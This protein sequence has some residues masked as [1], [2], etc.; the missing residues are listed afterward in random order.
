MKALTT[1]TLICLS[2][3]EI[4]GLES[5]VPK[6]EWFKNVS[7]NGTYIAFS[8]ENKLHLYDTDDG[9]L[10]LKINTPRT[11]KA[12]AFSHDEQNLVLMDD[13]YTVL[14][15]DLASNQKVWTTELRQF[16]EMGERDPKDD[17]RIMENM[18]FDMQNNRISIF[19]IKRAK[20][21]LVVLMALDAASGDFIGY[22]EEQ[23]YGKGPLYANEI[24]DLILFRPETIEAVYIDRYY[25]YTQ[26]CEFDSSGE[27]ELS[28]GESGKPSVLNRKEFHDFAYNSEGNYY[29]VYFEDK[30]LNDSYI[31]KY[32]YTEFA[33]KYK[34]G[35]IPDPWVKV[36][37]TNDKMI[38]I[39]EGKA[40]LF[41]LDANGDNKGNVKSTGSY[42]INIGELAPIYFDKTKLI[43]A[44]IDQF[45]FKVFDGANGNE[46]LSKNVAEDFKYE[47]T[48][49]SK[50]CRTT[51]SG[52]YFSDTFDD[53]ENRWELR[54]EHENYAGA[55]ENG[56]LK[57]K[58][59]GD[60]FNTISNDALGT[61]IFR[62]FKIEL[63][64]SGNGGMY[65]IYWGKDPKNGNK[66]QL[67][68][69]E[70]GKLVF[71]KSD[72]SNGLRE[73]LSWIPK[74]PRSGEFDQI[75]INYS[76][77][78]FNYEINGASISSSAISGLYGPE[79]GF[80]VDDK[81]DVLVNQIE[82]SYL[83]S[84]VQTHS[85]LI[86]KDFSTGK[87]GY[88]L[89]YGTNWVEDGVWIINNS[90]EERWFPGIEGLEL[91]ASKNFEVEYA[92]KVEG[93][94]S[95]MKWTDRAH[96]FLGKTLLYNDGLYKTLDKPSVSVGNVN[97][98]DFVRIKFRYFNGKSTH[99][100][101]DEEVHSN[102]YR[103]LTDRESLILSFGIYLPANTKMYIDNIKVSYIHDEV[104][105]EQ[106][107]DCYI[108]VAYRTDNGAATGPF[109]CKY[110]PIGYG[111][112]DLHF[113]W[114]KKNNVRMEKF[115]SIQQ[116]RQKWGDN[117]NLG[118]LPNPFEC[119]GP[120]R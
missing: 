54:K 87:N 46:L 119:S 76:Q 23:H 42:M 107:V 57:L 70:D 111:D 86:N 106:K 30:K 104:G 69:S 56:F 110:N 82:L 97:S 7:K 60:G 5:G 43:V 63:E 27:L 29:V 88:D 18:A 115:S 66:N 73:N 52:K 15:Y 65:G 89:T 81:A 117:P 105:R 91:S 75:T 84:N 25:R 33:F 120:C 96:S 17:N 9:T 68:F 101:N 36:A 37:S 85:T 118:T 32:K 50:G 102:E 83:T 12:F 71:T 116:F 45:H 2:C 95:G 47:G 78:I 24:G 92:V 48:A 112:H 13:E 21:D 20:S 3:F 114:M 16:I 98:D 40:S 74:P 113:E 14:N 59:G 6:F 39:S 4:Y 51:E 108:Y 11:I 35:K 93:G 94:F 22:T 41:D 103:Y 19:A 55:I 80:V 64:L 90:T 38:L 49:V 61:D 67:M 99:F 34:Q 77:G 100:I 62:D 1:I 10:K 44:D 28:G 26:E 53:N 79:L 58:K 109:Y 31:L 72:Q 8:Q